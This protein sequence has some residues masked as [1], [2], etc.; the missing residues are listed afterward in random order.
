M[1]NDFYTDLL[2]L[3]ASLKES[4]EAEARSD[5]IARMQRAFDQLAVP[6]V[7]LLVKSDLKSGESLDSLLFRVAKL[8]QLLGISQLKIALDIPGDAFYAQLENRRE[9]LQKCTGTTL[10]SLRESMPVEQNNGVRLGGHDFVARL[11]S[12]KT[13]RICPICVREHGLAR[14]HWMLAPLAVCEEHGCY[15]WDECPACHVA[16]GDNR[17]ELGL[18]R[19][20][21][22]FEDGPSIAAS[23]AAV[24]LASFIVSLY[25]RRTNAYPTNNSG[26]DF[27]NLMPFGLNELLKLVVFLGVISSDRK[28]MTLNLNRRLVS[29]RLVRSNFER[30]AVALSDWPRGLFTLLRE[31]MAYVS[32]QVTPNSIYG[33]LI[34]VHDLAMDKL[35]REAFKLI[36]EGINEFLKTPKAWHKT[37]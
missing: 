5:A 30:A 27:S 6:Q 23:A 20:G 25:T 11:V 18:C 28:N 1:Q 9:Q 16:L 32:W 14:A 12:L 10:E 33:S 26:F 4:R 19:C 21:A 15:L 34:H 22:R 3:E 24:A 13:P 29:M 31:G 36:S 7:N 35:D 37:D 17:P 2:A 8:N